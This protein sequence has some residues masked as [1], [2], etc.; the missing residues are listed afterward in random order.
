MRVHFK[1]SGGYGGL[2]AAEP[3][4]VEIDTDDPAVD[5]AVRAHLVGLVAATRSSLPAIDGGEAPDQMTYE[6]TIDDG[7]PTAHQLT[8]AGMPES[9]WPLVEYLRDQALAR[10]A[11]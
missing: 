2:F 3:L 4:E 5:A 11:G 10:R 6:I 9:A 7:V 8:D 1:M